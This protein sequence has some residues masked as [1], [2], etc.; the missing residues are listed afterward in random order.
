MKYLL[1][2][3]LT[4]EI[5]N[6]KVLQNYLLLLRINTLLEKLLYLNEKLG[7]FDISDEWDLQ[8]DS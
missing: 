8:F 7:T 3:K 5:F 6:T 2:Y 1:L 4:S